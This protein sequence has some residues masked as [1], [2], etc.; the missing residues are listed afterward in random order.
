[1][2]AGVNL[3]SINPALLQFCLRHMDAPD[4]DQGHL[5]LPRRDPQDLVWLRQALESL[6]S[7]TEAAT[8]LVTTL[9]NFDVSDASRESSLVA[10]LEELVEYAEDFDQAQFLTKLAANELVAL[11]HHS[12]PQVRGMAAHCIATASL[13]NVIAS[14]P[15][16]ENG[17]LKAVIDQMAKENNEFAA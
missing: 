1:M 2:P 3:N 10:V 4:F 9:R 11:L 8:R 15:L 14:K 6:E 13:Q 7:S 5:V 17:A 16:L 12:S